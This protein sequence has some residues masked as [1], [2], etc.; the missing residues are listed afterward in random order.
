MEVIYLKNIV[1]DNYIFIYTVVPAKKSLA[2]HYEQDKSG[3]DT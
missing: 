1:N 2:E 3:E